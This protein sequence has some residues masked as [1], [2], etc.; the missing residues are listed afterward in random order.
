MKLL[1]R[2][3]LF[4]IFLLLIHINCFADSGIINVT[5]VRLREQPNTTS[6]IITVIYEDEKVEILGEENDW[7]KI[8]Y[9]S[10]VGYIKKE[11]L[12]VNSSNNEKTNTTS[13]MNSANIA[14]TANISDN[15]NNT[16]NATNTNNV[17]LI[18]N[19]TNT[20]N[21]VEN[22]VVTINDNND[23]NQDKT[24]PEK[25]TVKEG[26]YIRLLPSFMSKSSFISENGKEYS[27][28]NELNEWVQISDGTSLGWLP[29]SKLNLESTKQNT[30]NSNSSSE[31]TIKQDT[32]NVVNNVNNEVKD[33]SNTT[34]NT[35][36]NASIDDKTRDASSESMPKTG[37]I[38]VETAR[39]R[40]GAST[41][42]EIIDGLDY[43]T[44]VEIIAENGE[45]YKIKSGDIEGY[46]SKRLIS[47]SGNT[48]SRSLTESRE[49]ENKDEAKDDSLIDTNQNN[50]VSTALQNA[51][52]S[53]PTTISAN[54]NSVVA[55]AKQY[56]GYPYVSAGKTP[57]SGFDC[58]GFTRY[59]FLNYGVTLGGSAAS[60]V[61]AGTEVSR[62]GLSA[63]DL[64][65]FYDEG[66]TKIGHTGIYIG[67]GDF[68]HAA[69]PS[70]GVVIDNLNSSTYYN[71]R[72]I[73][74]RRIVN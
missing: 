36:N 62:D 55:F 29:K 2:I 27:K 31:N 54:G 50:A 24:I 74:A 67:N 26:S 59:V 10:D 28:V 7:Y 32:E 43:G 21:L 68:I 5:A 16:I 69:N 41:T 60:Q 30:D 40:D 72:F 35:T 3:L 14:N 34:S 39:V 4:T 23:V 66:K 17:S 70:R 15:S 11:F 63:G 73:T 49:N 18:A 13:T 19:N 65:L 44:T 52:A 64:L 51:T 22:S 1:K 37:K 6:E 12:K 8:S 61:G 20:G 38:N 58:S 45:W 33:N 56:L 53:A 42:S 47:T 9:K 71:S 25:V 46:V 57:E 48:T